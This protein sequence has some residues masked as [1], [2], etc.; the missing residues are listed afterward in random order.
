MNI[1]IKL[2]VS[3]GLLMANT[4]MADMQEIKQ[5]NSQVGLQSVVL[6]VD[7]GEMDNAGTLLDTEKGSVPGKAISFTNMWGNDN[8]YFQVQYSRNEGTTDYVGGYLSPPTPYGSVVATST[9]ILTNYSMRL[10]TGIALSRFANKG[11]ANMLTP[12]F[13]LG[14]QEWYRGVNDGETYT[15]NYYGIGLLWQMS[16]SASQ[17]VFSVN[18]MAGQTFGANIDVS[19]VFSDA[20]GSSPLYQA[21]LNIDYALSK[22]LH[23]NAGVNYVRF[24]Y[25][26]SAAYSGYYEPDSSSTYL[27]YKAGLGLAF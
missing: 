10:G 5:S 22:I 17:L 4:A 7:Y 26:K 16:S 13:E 11:I 27:V 14:R 19:G 9:A 21:G 25:G 23:V 1:P 12:Y 2:Y 18:G 3:F 6:R 15:H 20:L 24:D 8:S